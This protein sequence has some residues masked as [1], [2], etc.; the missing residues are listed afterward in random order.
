MRRDPKVSCCVR[1]KVDLGKAGTDAVQ[2][3][4]CSTVRAAIRQHHVKLKYVATR[5]HGSAHID[6]ADALCL[7]NMRA[8][9]T[10]VIVGYVCVAQVD[11][12]SSAADA[13]VQRRRRCGGRRRRRWRR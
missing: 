12:E 2:R 1:C 9:T 10:E 5:R 11:L 6:E 3:C 4:I 13:R 7:A 8:K